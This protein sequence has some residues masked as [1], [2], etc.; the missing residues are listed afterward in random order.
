[1]TAQIVGGGDHAGGD[2]FLVILINIEDGLTAFRLLDTVAVAVINKGGSAGNRQGPVLDIP[3]NGLR[4][5]RGHVAVGVIRIACR[6]NLRDSVRSDTVSGVSVTDAVHAH[7]IAD[8]IIGITLAI[9]LR[10]RP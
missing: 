7:H 9:T 10:R 3:G 2:V 4:A 5:A 6:P 8:G 1:M